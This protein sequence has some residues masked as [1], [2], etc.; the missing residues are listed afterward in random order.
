M[1]TDIS[2]SAPQVENEGLNN[3]LDAT[4]QDKGLVADPSLSNSTVST[5]RFRAKQPIRRRASGIAIPSSQQAKAS[6]PK[7]MEPAPQS[8]QQASP[9]QAP[10]S[11]VAGPSH[12]TLA[13]A[14]PGAQ[15]IWQFMPTHG[16][17]K[18]T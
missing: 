3:T 7:S 13:A 14:G 17:N 5:K 1:D 9:Q 18:K 2:Q 6:Q 4:L 10:K 12:E 8:P 11:P 16:L 15:R